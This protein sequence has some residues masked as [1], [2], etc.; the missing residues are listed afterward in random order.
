MTGIIKI[1]NVIVIRILVCKKEHDLM[2]WYYLMPILPAARVSP[3]LSAILAVFY[4]LS[5]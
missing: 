2:S 3:L 1:E 4:E 5:S